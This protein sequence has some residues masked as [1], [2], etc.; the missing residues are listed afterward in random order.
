MTSGENLMSVGGQMGL[1]GYLISVRS[2]NILGNWIEVVILGVMG[3]YTFLISFFGHRFFVLFLLL[4]SCLFDCFWSFFVEKNFFSFDFL[5]YLFI[6]VIGSDRP[7]WGYK[8]LMD[9]RVGVNLYT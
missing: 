1:Q 7:P 4:F 9:L 5:I 6:F 2:Q 8:T 3:H